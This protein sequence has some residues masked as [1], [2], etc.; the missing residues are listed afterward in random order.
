VIEKGR[1][2]ETCSL[3]L[4]LSLP[5]SLSLSLS[6]SLPSFPSQRYLERQIAN[7]SAFLPLVDSPEQ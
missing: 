3:S 7:K 1:K 5:L 6:L 4:S 2:Q